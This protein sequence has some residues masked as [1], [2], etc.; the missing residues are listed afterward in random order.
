MQP[1]GY[2]QDLGL[3]RDSD[4]AATLERPWKV[5]IHRG[6]QPCCPF[7]EHRQDTVSALAGARQ[8]VLSDHEEYLV[9]QALQFLSPHFR[10]ANLQS[11][12]SRHLRGQFMFSGLF[13]QRAKGLKSA[14]MILEG[15][16]NRRPGIPPPRLGTMTFLGATPCSTGLS[17]RCS[18]TPAGGVPSTSRILGGALDT[19]GSGIPFSWLGLC[20]GSSAPSLWGIWNGSLC[21]GHHR[22]WRGCRYCQGRRYRWSRRSHWRVWWGRH[23]TFRQRDTS[24]A[25]APT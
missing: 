10:V 19:C 14:F 17:R 1:G 20:S 3:I 21:G 6:H 25:R 9:V 15:E 4:V 5:L 7:R 16:R 22:R 8:M 24:E 18:A 2:T 11:T 12:E 23:G 13:I